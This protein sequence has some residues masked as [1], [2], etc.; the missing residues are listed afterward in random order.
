MLRVSLDKR[1]RK[2]KAVTLITGFTGTEE[3]LQELGKMLKIKCGGVGGSAKEG[4]III[5][6]DHREKVLGILQKRDMQGHVSSD[7][8][9]VHVIK[10]SAGSGKTHR[11]TGEYL[12]LL[13]SGTNNYRHI[14]AVTFTNKATDEMKSR[15][16]EELHRL[17]SGGKKNLPT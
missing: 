3:D 4:E 11:L 12:R 13:Y 14:L 6:G 9:S 8:P 15:I 16:V 2:G 5:Q 10:A 1:N 17:A 7:R